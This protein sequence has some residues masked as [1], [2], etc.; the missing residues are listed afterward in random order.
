[1]PHDPNAKAPIYI[2]ADRMSGTT[3]DAIVAEGNVELKQ[4]DATLNADKV[5]YRQLDEETEAEGNVRLERPDGSISG[6]K[7]R[8]RIQESQGYIDQPVY[9]IQREISVKEPQNLAARPLHPDMPDITAP[10]RISTLGTGHAERIDFEGE[11][12][13]RLRKATYS[14]CPAGDDQDWYA[15][16]SDLKLDY[17][18][19]VGT[20]EDA[21][22]IFKGMPIMYAPRMSFSLNNQRK[23]GLLPPTFGAN[24]RIG[25]QYI[26]PYYWN[27][28][29]NMD[30]TISSRLMSRRGLQLNGQLRYLDFNYSGTSNFEYLPND[31]V[32]GR[33]R[34]AYSILHNQNFGAGFTGVL[35][36]NGV[37]DDDYFTDLSTRIAVISQ[38]NLLRQ[39]ALSYSGGWWSA[40]LNMQR[41]Q[42][43]QDPK[44]PITPP[45]AR[46]PQLTLN[47]A[48]PDLPYGAAFN[49]NAEHVT[50]SHPTNVIGQRMVFYPQLSLPLQTASSYLTPKVGLHSTTYKL[51]RQA[52]GTPDNITRQVPIFSLDSGVAFERDSNWFGRD[53]T[54]TL[55]PR[56]YYVYIP[57]R[58]QAQIP[59]F[60]T[61]LADFNFAQIFSENRYI[62]N[63]RI[64]DANQLTATITSRLID[65]ATGVESF[66]AIFGQRYYFSDQYVTLPNEPRRTERDA[67]LLAG[68]SGLI[69]PKTYLDTGLQYNPRDGRTERLN[70]L[71][72]YQPEIGKVLNAGYRYTRDLLG[73]IDVSAQWPLGG[74]WSGVGRYNYSTKEKRIIEG[75]AGFEYNAGCWA[76]RGVLQRLSTTAENKTTTFFIQLELSGFSNIGSNPNE[77]LRRNVPGYSRNYGTGIDSDSSYY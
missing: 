26:Q 30:A 60:D 54:Q 20:G 71:A 19:E 22:I 73:Q 1:M 18:R 65:P 25:F 51:E 52:L 40:G 27:I 36:L 23:T 35:N 39:G 63:D 32:A 66:R 16:I 38:G 76:I 70:V 9:A 2:T 53:F 17:D 3:D 44:N 42:T 62:G 75:L 77:V 41:Y 14:T 59:V 33:S 58:D 6:P 5:T 7:M 34:Y 8:M 28:A 31:S 46:L 48:R 68:L 37:S 21:K 49:L 45:Y 69:A 43:L 67:D 15:Q 56:L 55:E 11:G 57:Q 64:G 74:G 61:A 47:A 13:Y 12:H 50:F 29:P 10:R 24:S 72:R 4:L